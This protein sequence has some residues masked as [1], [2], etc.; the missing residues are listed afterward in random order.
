MILNYFILKTLWY[1]SA[2]PG[3]FYAAVSRDA[4]GGAPTTGNER[5]PRR[6]KLLSSPALG[7][8]ALGSTSTA[9]ARPPPSPK[10]GRNRAPG[11]AAT[12]HTAR[13]PHSAVPVPPAFARYR[14]HSPQL[15]RAGPRGRAG[16]G[17][18]ERHRALPTRRPP[19]ARTAPPLPGLMGTRGTETPGNSPCVVNCELWSSGRD[20]SL[21]PYVSPLRGA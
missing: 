9:G 5:G 13:S 21:R 16:P 1:S 17:R 6:P 11:A 15:G 8:Q 12:T 2:S 3:C 7:A 4:A 10:R 19:P 18:S 14:A 20:V